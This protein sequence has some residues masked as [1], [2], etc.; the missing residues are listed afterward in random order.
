S[1]EMGWEEIPLGLPEMSL[2]A[3]CFPP[4]FEK[5]TCLGVLSRGLFVYST[6]LKYLKETLFASE[7]HE[8][9]YYW[10]AIEILAG[11]LKSL[12]KNP[13][14]VEFVAPDLEALLAEQSSSTPTLIRHVIFKRCMLFLDATVRAY[15]YIKSS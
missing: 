8:S 4:D 12:M 15:I 10:K 5:E 13:E 14:T 9:N 7:P 3:K 11:N 1:C 2:Q 6:F